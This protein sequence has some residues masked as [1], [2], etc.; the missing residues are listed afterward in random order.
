M[1]PEKNITMSMIANTLG[2]NSFSLSTLRKHVNNNKWGFKN[3]D[4]LNLWGS[5]LSSSE[6]RMGDYRGYDHFRMAFSLGSFSIVQSDSSLWENK[7]IR[8]PVATFPSWAHVN[9]T[10]ITIL[11][12]VSFSRTNDFRGKQPYGQLK[13]TIH[14][15][16]G[17]IDIH[18]I[19]P[20]V[21]RDGGVPI[22]E[23][24]TVYYK[25]KFISASE[26][27]RFDPTVRV[28]S[29]IEYPVYSGGIKYSFYN[30]WVV[31]VFFGEKAESSF[32]YTLESSNLQKYSNELRGCRFKITNTGKASGRASFDVRALVEH[33]NF[34]GDGNTYLSK[35]LN[36]NESVYM[37]V[38]F[39]GNTSSVATGDPA[40]I[41]LKDS[42]WTIEKYMNKMRIS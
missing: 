1:L 25:F 27:R 21:P 28:G 30:E 3:I 4:G 15:G 19:Q 22:R 37:D 14:N 35:L 12:D 36:P 39:V 5:V 20:N 18:G 31:P 16:S 8:I 32:S 11:F 38:L 13:L 23:N 17:T 40:R 33:T 41:Y 34:N 26:D 29:Y 42:K 9:S 2:V 24:E 10:D 6:F 7:G